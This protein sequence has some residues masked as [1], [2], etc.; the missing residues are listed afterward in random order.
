MREVV[1]NNVKEAV[2][3]FLKRQHTLG[4]QLTR[5]ILEAGDH[6]IVTQRTIDHKQRTFV[7]SP[8][9][10]VTFTVQKEIPTKEGIKR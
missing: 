9:F 6:K 1:A 5:A 7:A 8:N 4:N 3:A 2:A 10:Y